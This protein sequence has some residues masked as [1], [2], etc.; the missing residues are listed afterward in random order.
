MARPTFAETLPDEATL[1]ADVE[2][3]SLHDTLK[4]I[5]T[6][7][8]TATYTTDAIRALADQIKRARPG[9][10]VDAT[11]LETSLRRSQKTAAPGVKGTEPHLPH[12]F[13]SVRYDLPAIVEEGRTS[14]S[15][16]LSIL[17]G[18]CARRL[19]PDPENGHCKQ[20]LDEIFSDFK[21][22]FSEV[23]SRGM[24]IV[25]CLRADRGRD[26]LQRQVI[27][28]ELS[29]T[30]QWLKASWPVSFALEDFISR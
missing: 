8:K 4:T 26:D 27:L 28:S 15:K 11:Q 16:E 9:V 23:S 25:R 2:N 24:G 20:P 12:L 14:N 21:R 17:L 13:G 19:G 3:A 29:E 7:Q 1:P 18:E 30:L 5:S 10:E 22:I 6:S